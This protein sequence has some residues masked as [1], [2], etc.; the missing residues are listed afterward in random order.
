MVLQDGALALLTVLNG[1]Q[2]LLA[3][4]VKD[5]HFR[6][7]LADEVER[8]LGQT[9]AC[10]LA[11]LH[12]QTMG[13]FLLEFSVQVSLCTEEDDASLRDYNDWLVSPIVLLRDMTVLTG[14]GQV[15]QQSIGIGRGEPFSQVRL[16]ELS[17]NAGC[18]LEG[19]VLIEDARELHR[20]GVGDLG[21]V[22]LVKIEDW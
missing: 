5:T 6:V 17:T 9:V 20:L 13:E 12:T 22:H 10:W 21:G 2:L 1:V 7:I 4:W 16:G 14:D 3:A 18:N 19:L 15:A 8:V 11:G